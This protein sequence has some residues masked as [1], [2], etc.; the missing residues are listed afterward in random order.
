MMFR[1]HLAFA[2]LIGL[3]FLNFFSFEFNKYLFLSIILVSSIIPDVD[4][5]GSKIGRRIKPLSNIFNFL[6]GHRGFLHSLLFVL[7]L[8]L[9]FIFVKKEILG[10]ALFLGFFS[11]LFLDSLTKEGIRFF[12]PL[13][14]KVNGFIKTNRIMEN[15]MFFV[16][17]VLSLFFVK[18]LF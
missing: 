9:I 18:V 8:F 2:F 12:Y 17:L 5:S 16:F 13:K 3:I 15:L 1:T 6:F 10:L 4:L 11:H 14:F 7:I